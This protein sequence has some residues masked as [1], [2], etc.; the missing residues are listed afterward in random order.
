MK[1]NDIRRSLLDRFHIVL[2]AE[3]GISVLLYRVF[4][5]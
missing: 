2:L 4:L 3:I 1:K 5:S